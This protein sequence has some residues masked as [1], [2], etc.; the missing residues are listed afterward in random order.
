MVSCLLLA[1]KNNIKTILAPRGEL[2]GGAF[3]KKYKKIPY[4]YVL[5]LFGLTKNVVFQSTSNEESDNIKKFLHAKNDRVSLLTNIPSFPNSSLSVKDKKSGSASFIFLSRIHPK[6]NLKSAI[7]YFRNIKGTVNFHI[8]GPLEDPA[9]WEEC[10]EDIAKLPQNVKVKYCGLV[11][12]ENIHKT[13]NQYD[14]FVFPTFSENYGHVIAEALFSFCP[15]IISDRTPWNDVSEYNAGFSLSL[16]DE[17][18]FA[19]AI[20]SIVDSDNNELGNN[21]RQYVSHKS[22][23]D[24]LRKAY[25]K[26]FSL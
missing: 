22:Q 23:I 6:K 18:G 1:K 10:N 20:Q 16:D 19:N 24:S 25:M 11:S 15:V 9:Y 4:I 2:C 3:K 13:F 14:A 5:R 26:L 12:H 7:S 8:Y 17:E 21:A